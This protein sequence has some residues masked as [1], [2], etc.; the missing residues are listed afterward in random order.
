MKNLTTSYGGAVFSASNSVVSFAGNTM[1]KVQSNIEL[2]CIGVLCMLKSPVCYSPRT[3]WFTC[4]NSSEN[5]GAITSYKNGNFTI[6]GNLNSKFS[7]NK[8]V[9]VYIPDNILKYHLVEVH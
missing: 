1:V 6:A 8:A 4:N 9:A 5:G 7:G 2:I 3:L